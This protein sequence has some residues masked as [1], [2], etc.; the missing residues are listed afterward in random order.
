MDA[1]EIESI[2]SEVLNELKIGSGGER[3]APT[4]PAWSSAKSASSVSPAPVQTT[5][6]KIHDYLGE[7]P[8]II[9]SRSLGSSSDGVYETV[10]QAAE[11]AEEAFFNLGQMTLEQRGAIIAAIRA[12]ALK[13]KRDFAERTVAETGMGRIEHK[14]KKFELVAA[15]TPGIEIL[16]PTCFTGDHGL[17]VDELAPFGVIGA[18]TPVTHPLPTMANNAIS[19]IAAGNTAVFNAHPASKNVFAYGVGVFNRAIQDAGGPPNL[20]TCIKEPTIESGKTLFHHPK[21]RLLL[22]T[23]GPAVVREAMR[24]PKRSICAGPGNPPVVV[25]ETADLYKAAESIIAGG[26]F[27][28]NILCIGEK[29]IFVVQ[30]VADALI[31]ELTAQGCFLLDKSQVDS[32]TKVAFGLDKGDKPSLNRNLVGR[33]ANVLARAFG[34]EITY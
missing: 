10:D 3:K 32:L 12:C 21:I 6:A 5:G 26:G 18:V 14:E 25:D 17:T 4:P 19:F 13:N 28:N 15:K 34:L 9:R 33:C 23:G 2:V 16:Q 24:A 30:E 7:F 22:V 27:D 8:S 31:K 1:N 20:I 29:Q 11:A